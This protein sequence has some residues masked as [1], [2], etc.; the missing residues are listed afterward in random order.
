MDLLLKM[1]GPEQMKE[2][3]LPMILG[4]MGSD[5]SQVQVN[6]Y[7]YS[8]KSNYNLIILGALCEYFTYIC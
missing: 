6:H 4:A 2:H 7:H 8:L 5:N 1:T 3:I